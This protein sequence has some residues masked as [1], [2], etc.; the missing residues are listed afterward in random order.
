MLR[1]ILAVLLA[2]ILQFVLIFEPVVTWLF[3]SGTP[4]KACNLPPKPK[5]PYFWA[6]EQE[7]EKTPV[8]ARS[9]GRRSYFNIG[10]PFQA[11]AR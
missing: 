3:E 8:F 11:G 5:P 4:L 10:L 1:F 7:D 6:G 9:R 2:F